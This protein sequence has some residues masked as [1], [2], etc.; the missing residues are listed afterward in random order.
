[1]STDTDAGPG[2]LDTPLPDM[3][4]MPPPPPPVDPPARDRRTGAGR[5]R[6]RS[7]PAA[8]KKTAAPAPR[9]P[10]AAGAQRAYRPDYR[11]GIRTLVES[12]CVPLSIAALRGDQ[13]AA[14]NLVTLDMHK[15][16]IA[17]SVQ[18]LADQYPAVDKYVGYLAQFGPA[19]AIVTGLSAPVL[20]MMTNAGMIPLPIALRLGCVHPQ[21][22]LQRLSTFEAHADQATATAAPAPAAADPE[23]ARD[24]VI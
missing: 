20:Q 3:P 11:A 21:V 15:D 19:G 23:P 5:T 13:L 17:D 18:Q 14:L 1:M 4:P 8:G 22:L 9:R 16:G 2:P 6:T 7:K 12:A 10:R 24:P